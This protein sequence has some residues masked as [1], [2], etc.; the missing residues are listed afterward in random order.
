MGPSGSGKSTLL[1][2][3]AG[4]ERVDS[5]RVL[6]DGTDITHAS[7]ADLTGLR[8]GRIGFVFQSYNLLG[9]LTAEEN[10]ALP[11]KLTRASWTPADVRRAL[12]EVGMSGRTGHHLRQ[13]SG[14]RQQ[15]VAIARALKA[16]PCGA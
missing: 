2:C 11:L 15:C 12:D 8:R 5:G 3:A 4:L 10:V 1:H 6:V 14:G 13:R 16:S 9:S 7:D